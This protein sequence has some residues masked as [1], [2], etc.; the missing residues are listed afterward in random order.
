M[1]AVALHA[2]ILALLSCCH[3]RQALE[4][5]PPPRAVHVHSCPTSACCPMQAI[6]GIMPPVVKIQQSG[7]E[8]ATSDFVPPL[9]MKPLPPVIVTEK[10]ESLD[11]FCARKQPDIF[12][13]I[14]VLGCWLL[15]GGTCLAWRCFGLPHA[16]A[17]TWTITDW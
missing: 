10:G 7:P 15:V 1:S 2:L 16:C 14:Q 13:V 9:N 8:L 4:P 17:I 11:E 12:T 6:Q 5:A 3:P